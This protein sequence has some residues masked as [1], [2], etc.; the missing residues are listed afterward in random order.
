[1]SKNNNLTGYPSQDYP[2]L[3]YKIYGDSKRYDYNIDT[4]MF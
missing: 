3:K 4:T 1:M 2:T